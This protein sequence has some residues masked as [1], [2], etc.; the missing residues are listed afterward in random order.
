MKLPRWFHQLGSPPYVYRLAERLCPWLGWLA[1]VSLAARTLL[2]GSAVRKPAPGA[3][4]SLG[5]LAEARG[6]T[7][8]RPPGSP[9]AKTPKHDVSDIGLAARGRQRIIDRWSW[10]HTAEKTV[11]QYRIRLEGSG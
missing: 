10:K 3:G 7:R 9:V 1:V 11:E 5:S 2:P 6:R 4:R 8:D